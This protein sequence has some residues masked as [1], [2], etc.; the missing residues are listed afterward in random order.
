MLLR[1]SILGLATG[2]L[3]CSTGGC[4]TLMTTETGTEWDGT[5]TDFAFVG[6]HISYSPAA[7]DVIAVLAGDT[8]VTAAQRHK[9]SCDARTF[10]PSCNPLSGNEV[11]YQGGDGDMDVTEWH[12]GR[13][14]SYHLDDGVPV[15]LQC[16]LKVTKLQR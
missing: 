9:D 5:A 13:E 6:L 11:W 12:G 1:M 3:L 7:T 14:Y 10:A 15:E 16:G 4:R 8:A 2:A